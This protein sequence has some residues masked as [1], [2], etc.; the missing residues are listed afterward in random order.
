[1]KPLLLG[2]DALGR[3][4]ELSSFERETHMHVIGSSGS[5]KSKFLEQMMRGDLANRQGFCLLDPHGSLYEDVLNFCSH[6]VLNQEIVLLNLSAPSGIIGFNPFRKAP[7]GDVSVQVDGQIRAVLRAWGAPNTDQTPTLERTLRLIFTTLVELELP[8]HAAQHMLNFSSGEIRSQ[9]VEK[10]SSA[11]IQ[12]EWQE[13]LALRAKD[14]RSEML[15]AKNRLLRLLTSETL[16]R[17]FNTESGG[18]DLADIIAKGKVLLVNLAPSDSLSEENGRVFGALLLNEF[19]QVARR[20]QSEPGSPLRPYYLYI[21]EFQTFVTLDVANMLD[22]VRKY[23]LF[24]VLAHQ[25]FGQ[26]DE[27][28]TDAVL[29]NCRIKAVFG[30]LPV[31]TARMMAQELFI[32]ELDPL[33]IKVAIYQT[34]FWPEYKRDKVYTR[35][36]SSGRSSGR[37]ENSASG[38]SSASLHGEFF[39]PQAWYADELVGSSMS[40]TSAMSSASGS[41]WNETDFV[42]D[43]EGEADVPILLPVP[44]QELSSVQYFPLEEQLTQLTAAL[45][46]QFGRHCFIKLHHEKTQ[47]LRVPLVKAHT[48]SDEALQWYESKLLTAEGAQAVE[49]VDA[50]IRQQDQQLRQTVATG[51]SSPQTAGATEPPSWADLLG[52]E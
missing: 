35:S 21:D 44:F 11:L 41:H 34:K 29:T 12:Q 38:H 42:G 36:T 20:R 46:N 8:F 5:G 13:L 25:R 6:K 23:K 10:L 1:M 4:V 22:Q 47:P 17:F 48:T 28:L 3:P 9:F 51:P 49:V 7:D 19:F 40:A 26:I 39:Q 43:A 2:H 30:G 14:W 33:R 45:K 37:G 31:E 27:D 18:I 15:S 50:A 32:G 24:A 52:R 16:A